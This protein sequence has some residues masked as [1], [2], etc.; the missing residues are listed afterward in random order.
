MININEL[1]KFL[2]N[3]NIL[4]YENEIFNLIPELK[5][6]KG[7]DQ[8][9]EWHCYDV[10][11]HTIATVNACDMNPVDRVTMLLHDIG[12]PFSYQDD[13]EK[14]HFKRHSIKS[15]EISKIILG[16]FNVPEED[17][18]LILKLIELHSIKINL[19]DVNSDNINFYR[20]LCRIQLYDAKGYEEEHSKMIINKLDSTCKK[21]SKNK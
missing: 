7:F 11:N 16:R 4:V 14:R 6:E 12:K 9:S 13:G 17:K 1:Y 21:L 15:V 8:K 18:N 2:L 5:Y 20:R 19:D 3:D 10:W